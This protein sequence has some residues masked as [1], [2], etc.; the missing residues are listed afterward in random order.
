ME[1]L[2]FELYKKMYL[3]R[4]TEEKIR[5]HY[6]EDEMKT[7]CHLYVG[8]EHI[9][10]GVIQAL[11]P[12]DYVFG[13]YRS[14]GIYLAKTMET[15]IFFAELY[16][17]ATG[18]A[19]GKAGSMHISSPRHGLLGVSAVVGTTIPLA[20]GCS[21]SQQYQN[22]GRMTAVFFGDGAIDEGVFWES[23]NLA[24]LKKLPLLFILE[25]ND[26]A[27]H[28]ST[29]ER[30]G[31]RSITA[32]V[33]QYDCYVDESDTTDTEE[34]MRLTQTAIGHCHHNSQPAFLH[35]KYYRYYEHVGMNTDFHAGYRSETVFH[36]WKARDP[37]DMQRAKLLNFGMSEEEIIRFE[38]EVQ[39]QLRESV[40]KAKAAPFPDPKELYTDVYA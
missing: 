21:F 32:I 38:Q 24:C 29:E 17:K 34:I 12:A 35:F 37:V 22:T 19:K 9:A 6:A 5:E 30:H 33:R 2:N 31:Y 7:P 13:T 1:N 15:D 39:Q 26:L 20:V 14:H 40:R 28:A 23:L 8:G 18:M 27:I 3:I 25:D 36:E 4:A 11:D 10:V 16:G